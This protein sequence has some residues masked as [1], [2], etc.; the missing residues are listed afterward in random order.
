MTEVIVNFWAVL[1][2]AIAQFAIGMVWYSPFLFAKPWMKLMKIDP[3]TMKPSSNM[4]GIIFGVS[5]VSSLILSYILA[6][7]AAYAGAMDIAGG[8]QLGF[9]VWLGFIVTTHINS[10]LYENKPFALF[11]I[12]AGHYLVGLLTAG[13]ILAA[14]R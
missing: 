2:A 7:F 13:A 5:L 12:N 3:E 10:V 6:H 14:W 8:L 4:M 9:W 1:T 11:A